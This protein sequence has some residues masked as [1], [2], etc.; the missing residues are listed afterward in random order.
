MNNR[1]K[2]DRL[3]TDCHASREFLL[4]TPIVPEYRIQ[5]HPPVKT[6]VQRLKSD[7]PGMKDDKT[8][9]TDCAQKLKDQEL[10]DQKLKDQKLKNKVSFGA[11]AIKID[12]LEP[13][14]T[15]MDAGIEDDGW[16]CL[17]GVLD[18]IA[19]ANK[20]RWGIVY[21]GILGLFIPG[22]DESGYKTV[23][24]AIRSGFG[25]K[26]QNTISIGIAGFP[27]N[28]FPRDR[29]MDNALKALDHAA[30]LGPDTTVGFDAV[31]LNISGDRL[32]AQGDL[33]GS[34][35]EFQHALRLDPSNVNVRNS[36]GVCYGVL[37]QYPDSL[38]EFEAAIR[39]APGEVM[40]IYNYGLV[41]MLTH[42]PNQALDH[43]LQA[44]RIRDDIFEVTFHIG[45]AYLQLEQPEKGLEYF[46]KAE[47]LNSKT[48]GVFRLMGRCHAILGAR[49]Q[50]IA[51]YSQAVR[52]NP[53]DA[54]ALS[55]LGR[56][57]DL[58]DKNL[59]IATLFCE[60]STQID[61]ENGRF[62]HRLGRLY[63]K[64]EKL[65]RALEAFEKAAALGYDSQTAI[66]EVRGMIAGNTG[67]VSSM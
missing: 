6:Q 60:R 23:A 39:S 48:A 67:E 45:K 8:F 49:D 41:K 15:P 38:S 50:A 19:A 51:A 62:H 16:L 58:R 18:E 28:D 12:A 35:N 7:F 32:Y 46:I 1:L 26:N 13:K 11:M 36:L 22:Q 14:T 10:K 30:F 4:N 53:N 55:D 66:N 27:S 56:Q 65:S 33:Q 61:P 34:I 52:I 21:K 17:A 42:H 43:F 31:S 37:K 2:Q 59:E 54:E 44:E 57:Y 25:R 63:L 20:G 9:V 47:S 5:R 64:A 24:E 3:K 29:I 40:A